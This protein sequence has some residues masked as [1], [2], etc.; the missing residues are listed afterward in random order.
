MSASGGLRLPWAS[1]V[2]WRRV[3]FEMC[4]ALSWAPAW[5]L[6]ETGIHLRA[7][8]ASRAKFDSTELQG[9]LK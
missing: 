8:G 2:W 9:L 1:E 7:L 3:S 6:R 4:G 5:A